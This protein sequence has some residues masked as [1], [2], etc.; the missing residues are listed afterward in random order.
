ML[1]GLFVAIAICA[2]LTQPG[3]VPDA[4]KDAVARFGAAMWN[5]RRDR[6]LTAAKQLEAAARQDSSAITPKRELIRVYS[7]LG[8]EPDAIR[9]A[10]ELLEHDP[11][12]GDTA[13]ALAR[14]Y[15]AVG[16]LKDAV[17]AAKLAAEAEWPLERADKA[18]AVYRDLATLCEKADDAAAAALALE[19]AVGLLVEQRADVIAARA[20]TPRDADT[21]AAECLERLGKVRTSQRRFADAATAYES[22][23][24]LFANP[25]VDDPSAAA[26]LAWNLSGV[27]QAGGEPATALKQLNVFLRLKPIAVEP[28]ERLAKLL[29]AAGRDDEVATL[30]RRFAEADPN[31]PTSISPVASFTTCR[32]S[33]G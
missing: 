4:H 15:F 18:V 8:R 5:L 31:N 12:D 23:A 30:L 21:A 26:R 32:I 13:H 14:L 27:Y 33:L 25:K 19:K 17:G 22:A 29:R 1:A 11:T 3:L 20:F 10:N 16:E 24:K 28:Y 2:P 7:Q 9:I 6:L